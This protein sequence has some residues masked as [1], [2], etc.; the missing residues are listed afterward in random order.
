MF[1]LIATVDFNNMLMPEQDPHDARQ[2]AVEWAPNLTIVK[3]QAVGQ[4]TASKKIAAYNDANSDG[5]QTCVGLSMYSIRTDAN[6]KVYYGDTAIP[7]MENSAH[8]TA[9]IWLRGKFAPSKLTGFDAAARV[10]LAVRILP[11]GLYYIP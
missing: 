5:T 9:P 8:D 11:N 1:G 10:D 4:I 6:G 7:S 3:G 2:D